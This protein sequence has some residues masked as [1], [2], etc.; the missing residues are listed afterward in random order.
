M[1]EHVLIVEDS[2]S[3]S[4][5]YATY[6]DNGGYQT[7]IAATGAEAFAAL[8]KRTPKA[9]LLDLNL[10]DMSG[11]EILKHMRRQKTPVAIIV[12]T[13]EASVNRAVEAMRMG[14]DDFVAKPVS[15]ERL[16][17][18]LQNAIEKQQ[19]FEIAKN[20]EDL[21]RSHFCDF[22]GQS[23]EMQAVYRI[24][25]NAAQSKASVF[26]TGESGTGKELCARAIHQ[27]SA[28]SKHNLEVINCAAIPHNLL[29]SEI[30]GHKK[31][32]FTGA[33]TDRQG[34]AYRADQGTMFLDELGEMPMELQSKLLRFIQTGT[35]M[36]V[37]A[38][39]L[40]EVDV[41][42][43]CAT[44]R[45]PLD[46]VKDNLLREDLYY[47]LN[48]IPIY[49]PP[50]RKRGEDIILLSQAFMEKFAKEEGKEFAEISASAKDRLY[51]YRWPGNIRE[52][53]NAIRNAVVLNQGQILEPD[54]LSLID[55]PRH[56]AYEERP[57]QTI[58]PADM[59]MSQ[60][61][62]TAAM[63]DEDMV[64]PALSDPLQNFLPEDKTQIQSLKLMEQKIIENALALCDG[65]ISEASRLLEINPSTIHRKKQQWT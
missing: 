56:E 9:I 55:Q 42:F 15:A 59:S 26:I 24:I 54:M 13:A 1:S 6:V 65:N 7:E 12:I 23:H 50:L 20:Y 57:A 40:E 33:M 4:Q 51:S 44:N 22:V 30:F 14:A 10:P 19:L 34:I 18:S 16:L 60:D 11:F 35:Y 41:R 25:E 61:T 5:T 38:S 39:V 46:A 64:A 49:M 63:T 48:V 27:L 3:L 21:T 37:G 29:E 62:S 45:E 28:R 8:E 2:F 36:P 32:A 31:G 53:E 43:V 47:R 52:L 58:A 17:I